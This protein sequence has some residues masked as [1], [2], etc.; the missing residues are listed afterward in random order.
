[1]PPPLRA[2]RASIPSLA[3]FL[4]LTLPFAGRAHHIDDPLYLAAARQAWT[5]PL[6]P[7]A[8]RASGTTSRP[9]CSTTSTTLRSPRTSWRRPWP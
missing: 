7:L 2:L 5:A 8:A 1:M 3:L 4:L 6:D 9:P